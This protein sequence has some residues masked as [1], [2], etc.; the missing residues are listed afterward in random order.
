MPDFGRVYIASHQRAFQP[1]RARV[2]FELFYNQ[3]S[4]LRGEK[5]DTKICRL[6]NRQVTNGVNI[7]TLQVLEAELHKQC[8]SCKNYEAQLCK[9]QTTLKVY[10]V[11]YLLTRLGIMY[12]YDDVE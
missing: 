9:T 12:M 5:E 8:E 6:V 10:I 3:T 4:C 2:V 7:L 11:A 1:I